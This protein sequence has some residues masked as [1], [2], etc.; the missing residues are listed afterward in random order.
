MDKF[1]RACLTMWKHQIYDILCL[2]QRRKWWRQNLART[3]IHFKFYLSSKRILSSLCQRFKN[4]LL[5]FYVMSIPNWIKLW[6]FFFNMPSYYLHVCLLKWKGG[7]STPLYE[8]L[9]KWKNVFIWH[10]TEDKKKV[11]WYVI[12]RLILD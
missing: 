1:H 6:N 9:Q 2:N 7:I 3:I 12:Q 8:E 11:L 5:Y 10:H 4:H